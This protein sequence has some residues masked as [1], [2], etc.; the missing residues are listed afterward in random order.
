MFDVVNSELLNITAPGILCELSSDI[1]LEA[2]LPNGSWGGTGITNTSTGVFSPSASGNGDFIITYSTDNG[3]SN[4]T[5]IVIEVV[6]QVDAT[7]SEVSGICV[8][9]NPIQ[10]TAADNGGTWTGTGVNSS[11]L[12][13]PVGLNAG[14]YTVTYSIEG[15]CQSQDTEEIDVLVVPVVSIV[16]DL[17]NCVNDP[18]TPFT[19]TPAGGTWSGQ[20]IGSTGIFNPSQSG[21]GT[22]PITYSV[23]GGCPS[24]N[25]VQVVVSSTPTII[26]ST[27]LEICFGEIANLT[28]SGAVG[29]SWTGGV[30]S[31]SSANTSAQP[32]ISTTYTVTGTNA[33]GC[34][35]TESVLV[36]VN[37]LPTVVASASTVICENESV[38]LSATGL[39]SYSWTPAATLDGANTSSPTASPAAT[40]TYTVT[41]TDANGCSGTDQVT[42]GV[43]QINVS[44]IPSST[45]GMV[46]ATIV[47]DPSTN[48]ED[49]LW[50][51]GNGEEISNNQTTSNV[52]TT[53]L[54]EGFYTV[55]LTAFLDGCEETV[56]DQI[57]IFN[58]SYVIVPNVVTAND[59]GDND[60]YRVVGN[61]IEE[62]EMQIYNR[63]GKLIATLTSIDEVFDATD[64]YSKWSPNGENTDGTYFYIYKAKGYDGKT[65]GDSGEITVLG[66]K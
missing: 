65:Y 34:Q 62:F 58:E 59:D 37:P 18:A 5:Q 23:G 48:G 47:F 11:G 21:A 43:T 41:G 49:V 55:S 7:I 13:S 6:D 19:A 17:A 16:G 22:V 24:S 44:F 40:T 66:L 60:F 31:P 63:N 53:Y 25:S 12:F 15:A 8:G 61:W 28:A 36:T 45:E 1:I 14:T 29:Y 52:S 20:G 30:N 57:I 9:G 10:L 27:D 35:S 26:A 33:A 3:C 50:D 42:V 51:F 54:N 2:N 56:T 39:T 38:D 32:N 46:P 4:S 64:S